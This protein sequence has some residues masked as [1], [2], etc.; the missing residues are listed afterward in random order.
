METTKIKL[1]MLLNGVH[2]EN[3]FYVQ[4]DETPA[5][6]AFGAAAIEWITAMH[7]STKNNMSNLLDF[8][9]LDFESWDGT[10][11]VLASSVPMPGGG[12]DN[13]GQPL[14]FQMAAV[15]I[16][17]T[18]IKKTFSRKFVPGITESW[19]NASLLHPECEAGLLVYGA[20]WTTQ[21]TATNSVTL[22]PGLW[23]KNHTFAQFTGFKV[24]QIMGTQR[25][26]KIG[27]GI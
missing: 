25:R 5:G 17:T 18:G 22:I 16:G 12:V 7:A 11:W 4:S 3:I 1:I 2:M 13:S 15:V 19:Q 6:T 9:R 10:S 26:R 14:P 21:F 24:D 8:A 20:V 23:R 27:V